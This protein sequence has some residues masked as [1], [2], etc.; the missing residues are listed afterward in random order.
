[1]TLLVSGSLVPVRGDRGS[2]VEGLIEFIALYS[3]SSIKEGK[4]NN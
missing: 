2:G 4:L 1:M 3:K